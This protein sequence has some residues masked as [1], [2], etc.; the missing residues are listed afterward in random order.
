MCFVL[1]VGTTEPLPRRMFDKDSLGLS[2]ESL[3]DR[4]AAIKQYFSKPEIQYVGS[5]SGCG[6]DFP[7]ATLQNG[8]WP[9][10]EYHGEDAEKN[11]LD[12]ARE[13]SDRQNCKALVALLRTTGDEMVELYGVWDGDFAKAPQAQEDIS[14]NGLLD[15]NFRLKEQGFY[16]VYVERET[17]V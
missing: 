14:I 12:N 15:R 13:V 1:Y 17:G 16:K 5:T 11:E 7:H 8:R 3:T 6:C 9:E 2:V 10:I 4:D